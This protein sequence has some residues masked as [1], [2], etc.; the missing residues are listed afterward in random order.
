MLHILAHVLHSDKIKGVLHG[1][2]EGKCLFI[3]LFILLV[4]NLWV[5]NILFFFFSS[6]SSKLIWENVFKV[7]RS[8][9][10]QCSRDIILKGSCRIFFSITILASPWRKF[11]K[12]WLFYVMEKIEKFVKF[13]KILKTFDKHCKA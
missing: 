1:K 9:Y 13:W 7:I 11:W 4:L 5:K 2:C 8:I 3:P 6:V 12:Y 10:F